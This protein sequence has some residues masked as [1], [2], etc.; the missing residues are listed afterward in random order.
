MEWY[1]SK[2]TME[3]RWDMAETIA[4]PNPIRLRSSLLNA[5]VDILLL[6]TAWFG[7][8]VA[9]MLIWSIVQLI[10]YGMLLPGAVPGPLALILISMPSLYMA[11]AI[12]WFFRGRKLQLPMLITQKSKLILLSVSV[13][14]GLFVVNISTTWA[15][16]NAGIE[17]K[18]SN[19]A[20]IEE[21]LK[22]WPVLTALFAVLV[23]PFFEE[24]F[25]R[26]QLFARFAKNGH[27][28]AGF[29][30]SSLM[31]AL[32]H[33]LVPTQGYGLWCLMLGIYGAMGAVFAWLYRKTGVLWTAI[34]AHASNN[35]LAVVLLHISLMYS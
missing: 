11:I 15:L 6:C 32:M 24:L 17:L 26:K 7:L 21:T 29:V 34:L 22:K 10:E 19:Q 30:I 14:L 3:H 13:G 1:A 25:F 23:A 33:E 12:V 20:I 2:M 31:F 9:G 4:K 28:A 16:Q 8:M 27:V 35:L 18:P 5:L